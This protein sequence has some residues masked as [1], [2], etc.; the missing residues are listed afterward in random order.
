LLYKSISG[1]CDISV[2]R[3]IPAAIALLITVGACF[4]TVE[5]PAGKTAYI[6]AN[7]KSP[8]EKRTVDQLSVYLTGVLHTETTVVASLQSVPVSAPAII[9]LTGEKNPLGTS[10]P[11]ESPEGFSLVTGKIAQRDVVVAVG[12]SDRG[13]KRAVQRLVIRSQQAEKRLE[14]PDLKLAE[15]PWIPQREW[16]LCPWVP[17]NVRGTYVNPY[18]DQRVNVY[19]FTDSQQARYVQMFDSFGFSGAQLIEGSNSWS[20]FGSVE[21]YQEQVKRLARFARD[22]GQQVTFWVWAAQFNHYGWADLDLVYT[23][24]AGHTAFSDPAVRKGFEKYYDYYAEM[25]PYVDRLISHF[26]DPGELSDRQDVFNYM[27]L[28]E[29]KFKAKNPQIKMSI[30][31]WGTDPGYF[32][33]LV[34]NGFKDYLLLENSIADYVPVHPDGAE[35]LRVGSDS[36]LH[37]DQRSKIHEAAK[38]LN[39]AIGMW[40]WYDTEYETDQQASMYVNAQLFK[41]LVQQIKNGAGKIHPMEYWSEM[42]AGH[43]NN[44]CSMYVAGQLLWNPDRDPDELVSEFAE[45]IWGPRN[46]PKVLQALRLVQDV[47]TGPTWDT[48]WWTMSGYRRGTANPAEDLRRAESALAELKSLKTDTSFVPKFPLP[49][50]PDTLI[51]LMLPHLQQIRAFAEFRIELDQI[52]TAWKNGTSKEEISQRLAKAWKPIPEY[53]TWVGVFGQTERRMQEIQLRRFAKEVGVKLVEP[54]WLRSEDAGRLLE[55]IQ[56]VQ[57]EQRGEVDFKVSDLNEFMWTNEKLNNRFQKLVADGWVAKVGED[58]Y[59]LVNWS[60]Y[61]Q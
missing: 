14:I 35:T 56:N 47:R 30:D 18:A 60:E 22:N 42:D 7:P 46:G 32:N 54:T 44:L 6:V 40:G 4:G 36:L 61:G 2:F 21:A 25:A 58:T 5:F 13:L 37:P 10:A 34:K 39:L 11:L 31:L 52:K 38:R 28:L 17:W 57:R 43:L 27:R 48:Y 41:S 16:A 3:V 19:K 15:K 20:Y 8:L 51:E 53:N 55:K 29:S 9:L 12:N 49:V 33:E 24:S 59:R 1:Y 45:G 50:S 26:Y 23:P